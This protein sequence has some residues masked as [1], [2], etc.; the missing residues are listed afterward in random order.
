[1]DILHLTREEIKE[2]NIIE[3]NDML[4]YCWSAYILRAIN[5][6]SKDKKGRSLGTQSVK[7]DF[8]QSEIEDNAFKQDYHNLMGLSQELKRKI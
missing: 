7:V 4:N 3:M 2:L 1:M 8:D 5:L 6:P